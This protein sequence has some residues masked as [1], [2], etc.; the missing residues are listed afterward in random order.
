MLRN[1]ASL[2]I[3]GAVILI[4]SFAAYGEATSVQPKNAQ[5]RSAQAASAQV[6]DQSK[7]SKN[8]VVLSAVFRSISLSNI[9][10]RSGSTGS[11]SGSQDPTPSV[12]TTTPE[13]MSLVLLGTGITGVFATLRKRRNRS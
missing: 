11:G 3:I 4:S 1:L 9:I 6:G 5:Q 8:P 10:V 7:Q 12:A 2:M 13:P